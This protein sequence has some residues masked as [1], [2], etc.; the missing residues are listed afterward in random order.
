MDENMKAIKNA[1]KL[2]RVAQDIL[3][4]AAFADPDGAGPILDMCC[5]DIDQPIESHKE[6]AAALL[7]HSE[8]SPA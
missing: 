3:D 4:G 6:L 5:Q 2:L 1:L 8:E 7:K